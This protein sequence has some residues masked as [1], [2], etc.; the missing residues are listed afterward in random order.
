MEDVT[1]RLAGDTAILV[2]FANEINSEVNRR[3]MAFDECL[4]R[5]KLEGIVETVP[6]YRSV[7][8]HYRPEIISYGALREQ[9]EKVL[10]QAGLEQAK[11]RKVY[12]IP[13]FYGGEQGPDL[14]QVA[15]YSKKTVEEVIRIH[16]EPEY[17][18]YMLGFTPG[19]PYLGGMDKSIAVPRLKKPRVKIPAGSIGIAGEQTGIYPLDS[20]GGWQLIGQTPVKLYDPGKEKAILLEAGSFIKFK[21]VTEPEFRRLQ[22]M[23]EAGECVCRT[24][25]REIK[26]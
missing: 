4:N 25:E 14:A 12:E 22:Q 11:K 6:T 26:G 5:K 21:P 18:I 13:V 1:F 7:T 19:F 15:E 2:E 17:L 23:A 20:P 16:S 24:F 3:V 10:S 8:V 9:L